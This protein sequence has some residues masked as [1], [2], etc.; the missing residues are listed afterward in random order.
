MKDKNSKYCNKLSSTS[1]ER[2]A[3]TQLP[4]VVETQGK[5][6]FLRFY[7]LYKTELC[8]NNGILENF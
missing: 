3:R 8:A 7:I 4:H 1:N 2:P 5:G 6:E